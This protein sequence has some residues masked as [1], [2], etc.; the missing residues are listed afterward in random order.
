MSRGNCASAHGLTL[1]SAI[2]ACVRLFD[3]IIWRCAVCTQNSDVVGG[4]TP[5]L[6]FNFGSY[7]YSTTS[8]WSLEKLRVVQLVKKFPAFYGTLKI[9]YCVHKNPPL[10]PITS[11]L[12]PDHALTPCFFNILTNMPRS[13]TWSLTFRLSD[14]NCTYIFHI[15]LLCY[16]SWSAHSP[17]FRALEM[18]EGYRPWYINN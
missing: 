2:C 16:M 6:E 17:W 13:C 18:F 5:K 3:L 8:V 1:S 11:Q 4:S 14:Q 7:G 10:D 12:N 15:P 9:H